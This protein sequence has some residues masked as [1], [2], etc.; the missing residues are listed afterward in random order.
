MSKTSKASPVEYVRQ[1][2]A[3]T[4][5]VTWPSRKEVIISAIAVFIMSF[6]AAVFLYLADQ[7]FAWVVSLILSIGM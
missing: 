6:L 5:K 3:E 1:V 7:L 4:R 2:K